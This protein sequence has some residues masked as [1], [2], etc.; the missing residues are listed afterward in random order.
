MTRKPTAG[1]G[2]N[3]YTRRG[4]SR[5]AAD[6]TVDE[7][8]AAVELEELGWSFTDE[9]T[10]EN[11]A[12]APLQRKRTLDAVARRA[13]HPN[14][15]QRQR[16]AAMTSA[17]D[18]VLRLL[19]QDDHHAVRAEVARNPNCPPDVFADLAENDPHWKVRSAAAASPLMP[20]PQV[21]RLIFSDDKRVRRSCATRPML[22][23]PQMK[24]L[25]GDPEHTVREALASNRGVTTAILHS[26][27]GDN[28]QAVRTRVASNPNTSVDDLRYLAADPSERVRSAVARR[29]DCPD[30]V[31]R[32]LSTD[33]AWQVN[34][35]ATATITRKSRPT[36]G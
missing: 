1:R 3:Q 10:R 8:R 32:R 23:G 28:G 17:G 27:R 5:Q 35:D 22:T 11:A 7:L 24:A 12:L 25:A 34:R 4:T 20:I 31:L 2:S 15:Y 13:A 36:A 33:D 21:D 19:A 29:D 9:H 26:L 6:A 16:V 14:P 30:D 18:A